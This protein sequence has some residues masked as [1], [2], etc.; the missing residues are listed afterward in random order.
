MTKRGNHRLKRTSKA[1]ESLKRSCSS[2]RD[3]SE[4]PSGLSD[5]AA[6]VAEDWLQRVMA[7]G[8]GRAKGAKGSDGDGKRTVSLVL[9]D[10]D[11]SDGGGECEDK[12]GGGR[13][14]DFVEVEGYGRRADGC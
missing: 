7:S 13:S 4:E 3:G 11:G 14:H 1:G 2:R 5:D 10:G 12:E 9:C 8:S 6:D